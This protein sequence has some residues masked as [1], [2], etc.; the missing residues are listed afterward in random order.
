MKSV[1][2]HDLLLQQLKAATVRWQKALRLQ[3]WDII[4]QLVPHDDIPDCY[5]KFVSYA[6]KKRVN[7]R[8][9]FPE[10]AISDALFEVTYD[11]FKTLIHELLH[12]RLIGIKNYEDGVASNAS[13][14][15][16]EQAV[17]AL[18]ELLHSSFLMDGA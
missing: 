5:G 15:A 17:H 12:V 2:E 8:L 9:V 1:T 18:T 6:S 11:P 16:E 13:D 14:L 7:I 10:H 3:D 4:V